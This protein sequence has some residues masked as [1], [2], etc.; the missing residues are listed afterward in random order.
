MAINSEDAGKIITA[1]AGGESTVSVML[2]V[3]DK[4]AIDQIKAEIEVTPLDDAT[5][6][7]G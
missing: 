7:G 4:A 3:V 5:R 1:I 2:F 6:H